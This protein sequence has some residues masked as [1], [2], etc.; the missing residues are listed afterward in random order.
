[1][2]LVARAAGPATGRDNSTITIDTNGHPN[3][4]LYR[5]ENDDYFVNRE[6]LQT[7]IVDDF[8]G[9]R[10]FGGDR[11]PDLHKS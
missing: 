1:M 3:V 4:G 10:I 9:D 2:V 6:R 7:L 11:A 5:A 8:A